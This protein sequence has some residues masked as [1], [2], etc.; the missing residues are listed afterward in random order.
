[1]NECEYEWDTYERKSRQKS[2]HTQVTIHNIWIKGITHED[3]LKV[4]CFSESRPLSY[5]FRCRETAR[6]FKKKL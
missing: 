5:Q 4:I 1:M 3:I 6:L 2:V